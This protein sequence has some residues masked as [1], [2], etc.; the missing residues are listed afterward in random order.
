MLDKFFNPK[1]IAVIGASRKPG[2]VGYAILENLKRSF[3]GKIYPINPNAS[4][5]LGLKCYP[6]V[7]DID[8]KIDLAIIAV[9]AEIVES[10]VKECKKA[11]IKNVII[12]SSGFSE[13]GNE[14]SEKNLQN[15]VKKNKI[16]VIGPNCIGVFDSY[17][18]MDA[19]FWDSKKTKKPRRGYVGFIS[20]SGALGV[21]LLD[22]YAEKGVGISKF[23]S[24]GNK[25]DVDEVEVL[26]YFGRD[27]S[28][29]VVSMYIESITKGKE[30]MKVSREVVRKK[31]IV[32]LK[33]GKTSHGKKAVK[34]H[35]G[36]LAGEYE[37][38]STAF[39]QCGVIEALD[40]EE[41]I[42]YTK[43][44]G[45]QTP[46]KENRICIV[47]NGGGFGIIA[48]DTVEREG[49]QVAELSKKTMK[50]LEKI[51]PPHA[52]A[53][54]PVDLTGDANSEL[55]REVLDIVLKDE[56]VDGVCIIALL[57]L[58][59][60]DEKIVEVL[61]ECRMYEKSFVVCAGGSC[62]TME[63]SRKLESSGIPVYP[64]PHRA[65]K[66]LSVLYR[67]GNILKKFRKR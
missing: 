6:S 62:Y 57:Q 63:I 28:I 15:F 5:I 64:T 24:L 26:K 14:K 29:R 65:I 67:Y 60:L 37:V 1:S 53:S 3:S 16:R 18:G 36:A 20:Q 41:L 25:I 42:D 52:V 7:L 32:V 35:T 55:Y 51:L 19:L 39:R 43:V 13:V 4:E 59:P 12:I 8:E 56:N 17:S 31:P 27:P 61:N 48:T 21:S 9:K 2:K 54:N 34:S 38:Y 40:L 45:V 22:R 58:A 44:L 46:M 49:L 23:V 30:F 33:A 50:K 66:A 11:G 47:T 10:V